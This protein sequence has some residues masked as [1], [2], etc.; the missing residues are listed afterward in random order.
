MKNEWVLGSSAKWTLGLSTTDCEKRT[1]VC[2][3]GWHYRSSHPKK[4]RR[5]RSSCLPTVQFSIF[6]SPSPIHLNHHHYCDTKRDLQIIKFDAGDFIILKKL[7]AIPCI[8]KQRW[9]EYRVGRLG[10]GGQYISRWKRWE[11]DQRRCTDDPAQ[12]CGVGYYGSYCWE[13]NCLN[14]VCIQLLQ[15][16]GVAIDHKTDVK[17]EH[18]DTTSTSTT[19]SSVAVLAEI[20][21]PHYYPK[22]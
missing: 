2:C 9:V 1:P 11:S 8:T 20:T 21:L 7:K 19:R 18:Y 4:N 16:Y 12:L 15:W 6:H 3:A 17:E 22:I 14:R 10:F 5:R 13:L